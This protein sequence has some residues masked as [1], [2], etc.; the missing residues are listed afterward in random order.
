MIADPVPGAVLDDIDARP[1]STSSLLRTVIGLF[2]RP[3]GGWISA[4][5]LVALAGDLGISAARARTGITR[6]KQKGLLLPER[7]ETI[8]YRLDPAALLMLERGDRRIFE[9]REMTDADTWCLVS[10]SIPESARSI[11]HQLRRRLQWIGAGIVSPALWICPGHLQDEAL[12]IIDDLGARD[13]VTLFEAF[14][15][16]PSGSLVDAAAQWW[17]LTAL[18]AEHLAFQDS[19]NDLPTEPFAAYVHLIDRWRVLPYTDPGLPPSMLPAD[20]PGRRSFDE[21]ARRSAALQGP[22]WEHV[23]ALT[24]PA[25]PSSP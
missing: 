2:L 13:W 3:L 24:F 19:L 5:D 7:D 1:G 22:A 15:P 9:M 16:L 14:A 12:E 18:R 10:F 23:R 20:W 6:L 21:F 4:A 25:A 17:D 8:G 11:R